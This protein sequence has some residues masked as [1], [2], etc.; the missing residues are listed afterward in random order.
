MARL[1]GRRREGLTCNFRAPKLRTRLSSGF[2]GLLRQGYVD[3]SRGLVVLR[4]IQSF[5]RLQVGD[6]T[7]SDR[8]AL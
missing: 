6:H 8:R 5:L 1:H 4:L 7:Q 2:G 3:T